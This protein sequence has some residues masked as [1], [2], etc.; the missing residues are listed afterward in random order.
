MITTTRFTNPAPGAARYPVTGC[1]TRG[2]A[3]AILSLSNGGTVTVQSADAF[4]RLV[5][6]CRTGALVAEVSGREARLFSQVGEGRRAV[7]VPLGA[8]YT[9]FYM[10][11]AGS[12]TGRAAN[13]CCCSFGYGG[14]FTEG[15]EERTSNPSTARLRR[16]AVA[17]PSEIVDT[18]FLG[19]SGGVKW[20]WQKDSAGAEFIYV[21]TSKTIQATTLPDGQ[22]TLTDGD[23]TFTGRAGSW[24]Y[25]P[26]VR[27]GDQAYVIFGSKINE[28]D[29][30]AP[31]ALKDGQPVSAVVRI[32]DDSA[33]KPQ[34]AVIGWFSGPLTGCVALD[35]NTV[36]G[37]CELD[38]VDYTYF[39]DLEIGSKPYA[40]YRMPKRFDFPAAFAVI[41]REAKGISGA[42]A[43]AG[44]TSLVMP[45]RTSVPAS[46]ANGCLEP[47]GVKA[48]VA[49]DETWCCVVTEQTD[50]RREIQCRKDGCIKT[51]ES[52]RTAPTATSRATDWSPFKLLSD[53][54]EP[55]VASITTL[56]TPATPATP[57]TPESL[58]PVVL[59]G[60]DATPPVFPAGTVEVPSHDGDGSCWCATIG[61]VRTVRGRSSRNSNPS[62]VPYDDSIVLHKVEFARPGPKQGQMDFV[63]PN[64]VIVT[65][66]PE[67]KTALEY[68]ASVA[69]TSGKM[70][71]RMALHDDGSATAFYVLSDGSMKLIDGVKWRHNGLKTL[72]PRQVGSVIIL[73]GVR[74]PWRPPGGGKP[75]SP[76]PKPTASNPGCGCGPG[77]GCAPCKAKWGDGDEDESTTVAPKKNPRR[78]R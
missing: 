16:M 77:C 26:G 75:T 46:G 76:T 47:E 43:A 27:F 49:L 44:I 9:A 4:N 2:L 3:G 8:N 59:T 55:K 78:Y 71:M 61:G 67:T 10:P 45:D 25:A 63:L 22:L 29:S 66:T 42:Q 57:V 72:K 1:E 41:R 24:D 58:E 28:Y 36:S 69:Y 70:F 34:F 38:K 14:V 7:F 11:A 18:V 52:T 6:L 13:P 74:P 50:A 53:S 32:E 56:T 39:G 20:I 31:L 17:N 64:G 65:A 54:C 33:G 12:E 21:P 73:P 5:T 60:G 19:E 51:Y 37:S 62:G 15:L 68:L 48:A 23:K 40:V 30:F 35:D